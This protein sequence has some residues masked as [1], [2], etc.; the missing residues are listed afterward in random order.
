MV[1]CVCVVVIKVIRLSWN[2]VEYFEICRRF[3]YDKS[4]FSLVKKTDGSLS[5][6][7]RFNDRDATLVHSHSQRVSRYYGEKHEEIH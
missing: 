3:L 1:A 4:N 6:W 5:L 7:M 2:R